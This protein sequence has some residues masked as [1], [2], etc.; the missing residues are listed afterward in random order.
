MPTILLTNDDGISSPAL[1]SL[2]RVLQPLGTVV[3][4]APDRNY[5]AVARGITIDRALHIDPLTF[6]EADY[7]GNAVDG[8]P[9]DCVR[10]AMLDFFGPRPDFV[11]SGI[12]TGANLGDDVTYSGTVAAALE[13]VLLGLP[14]AAISVASR[15][16]RHL[17][18]SAAVVVPLIRC[19]MSDGLPPRTLIN[20]NIPELPLSAIKGIRLTHL[21]R[22]SYHDRLVVESED[23]THN[24]Y[25]MKSIKDGD[26]DHELG[27]DFEAVRS[28]YVSLTPLRFDLSSEPGEQALHDWDLAGLFAETAGRGR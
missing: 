3:T 18:E 17:D 14:A 16:P 25:S 19:A 1:L 28:G 10:V 4:I 13:G 8:T 9:V 22:A 11:V 21:G 24:T 20:I 15:E 6:G 23:G 12:N 26:A 5:S 7:Y 2:R 27:S